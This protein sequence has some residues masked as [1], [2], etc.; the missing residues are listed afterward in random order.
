MIKGS[1]QEE[2]MTVVNTFAPNTRA[3]KYTEQIL[4]NIKRETD[5]NTIIVV[6]STHLHQWTDHPD[7]ISI[8]KHW[9]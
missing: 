2:D 3:P 6:D 9:P 4:T 7:R 8:R 1:I 5:S